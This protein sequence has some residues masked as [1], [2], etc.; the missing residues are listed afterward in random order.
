MGDRSDDEDALTDEARRVNI[1]TA[2]LPTGQVRR[3]LNLGPQRGAAAREP[4]APVTPRWTMAAQAS[5]TAQPSRG[6]RTAG[7]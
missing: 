7:T 2:E 6:L 4:T 5:P 1:G 3:T